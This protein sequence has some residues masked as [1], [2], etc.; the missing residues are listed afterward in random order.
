MGALVTIILVP[1]TITGLLYTRQIL[2][3]FAPGFPSVK[4]DLCIHFTRQLLPVAIVMVLSYF[5]TLS[6]QAQKRFALASA[7][8]C[9]QKGIFIVC[10]V[11][12]VLPLG[13]GWI[14]YAYGISALSLFIFLLVYHIKRFSTALPNFIPWLDLQTFGILVW[15]LVIGSGISQIGRLFQNRFASTLESGSI[16]ALSFAQAATDLPLMLV[17]LALSIVLMPHWCEF[18]DKEQQN[19]SKEY[20][21]T[22]I[23]FL[24]LL[25]VPLG[26]LAFVM[27]KDIIILLFGGGAFGGR[28][29]ALTT[30]AMAWMALGLPILAIEIILTTFFFSHKRVV[31]PMICGAVGT[32]IGI[33][34]LPFLRDYF[35]L[36]G[37]GAFIPLI[38]AI[39]VFCLSLCLAS[40]NVPIPWRRTG[41]FLVRLGCASFPIAILWYVLNSGLTTSLSFRGIFIRGTVGTTAL[42]FSYVLALK[43]CPLP[44]RMSHL[45]SIF[46][47]GSHK[48]Q[49]KCQ[50]IPPTV[51]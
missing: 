47:F 7:S 33:I 19:R 24:L 25:F 12:L 6:L 30:D 14:T 3:F 39:K 31:A 11:V 20:L 35:H 9:L 21:I 48:Q 29:V 34:C 18:T 38:R 8:E 41:V 43:L 50:E 46:S 5:L 4:I 45:A 42:L 15:P 10:V 28:S 23:R 40:L 51:A 13:F 1:A 44:L 22:A 17:P 27:R 16:A 37:I 2:V 32:L 49:S 26:A 36:A